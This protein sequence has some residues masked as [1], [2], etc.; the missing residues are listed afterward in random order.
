MSDAADVPRLTRLWDERLRRDMSR[1]DVPAPE[2]LEAGTLLRDPATETDIQRAEA[3]LGVT[4]PPAYR[5][6]LRTSNGAGPARWDPSGR[7]G[8][9]RRGTASCPSRR[10]C[11]SPTPN[12]AAS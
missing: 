1:F 10:S 2:A 7:S 3:R 4:L 11:A 9:T 6:F 5:G 12:T 8:A